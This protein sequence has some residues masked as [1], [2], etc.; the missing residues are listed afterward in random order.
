MAL[1]N[2]RR[3]QE[4]VE[5]TERALTNKPD[6]PDAWYIK[7]WSLSGLGEHSEAVEWLCR[8]WRVRERLSD[9]GAGVASTLNWLGYTPAECE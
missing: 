3:Y 6:Y 4:S 7:G 2:L 5:A 9:K 8:A 1:G